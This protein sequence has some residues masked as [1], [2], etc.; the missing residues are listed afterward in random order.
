VGEARTDLPRF[1]T[2]RARDFDV[3]VDLM[4]IW[5]FQYLLVKVCDHPLS[6]LVVVYGACTHRG[7]AHR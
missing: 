4:T 1:D 3:E 5:V 2:E 7:T 6:D